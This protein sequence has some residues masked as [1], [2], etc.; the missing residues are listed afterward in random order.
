MRVLCSHLVPHT[1]VHH[2]L[3]SPRSHGGGCRSACTPVP[4]PTSGCQTTV[5]SFRAFEQS[6]FPCLTVVVSP[7]ATQLEVA[8]VFSRPSG[9]LP[10]GS[11]HRMTQESPPAHVTFAVSESGTQHVPSGRLAFTSLLSRAFISVGCTLSCFSPQGSA[12]THPW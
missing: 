6:E 1:R 9:P 7:E 4:S 8:C 5:R 11:C 12:F 3:F 10:F 2:L